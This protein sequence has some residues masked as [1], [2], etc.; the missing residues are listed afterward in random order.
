MCKAAPDLWN[1]PVGSRELRVYARAFEGLELAPVS[2]AGAFPRPGF[3]GTRSQAEEIST[4]FGV[5]A[6]QPALERD[7]DHLGRGM[8][9]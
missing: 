3:A 7:P 6:H 1:D 4:L 9:L 5:T 2:S 8:R